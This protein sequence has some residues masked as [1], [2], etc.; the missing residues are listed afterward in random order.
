MSFEDFRSSLSKQYGSQTKNCGREVT[1]RFIDQTPS[2][3]LRHP[4][5][6]GRVPESEA[7]SVYGTLSQLSLSGMGTCTSTPRDPSYSHSATVVVFYNGL[8]SF[9]RLQCLSLEHSLTKS[10]PGLTSP[11]F[12]R[13]S[14]SDAPYSAHLQKHVNLM[15]FLPLC[16]LNALT[17]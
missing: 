11:R 10:G 12:L 14:L 6:G 7:W 5:S 15:R 2:I 13:S 16:Y 8:G 17:L 3:G 1:P 9:R 4:F